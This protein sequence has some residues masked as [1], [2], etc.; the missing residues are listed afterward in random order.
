[1]GYIKM[2]KNNLKCCREA[3]GMSQAEVRRAIGGVKDDTYRGWESGERQITE[4][5]LKRIAKVLRCSIEDLTGESVTREE[6]EGVKA[7]IAR[8]EKK[9]E[10]HAAPRA[11]I[12]VDPVEVCERLGLVDSEGEPVVV[13]CFVRHAGGTGPDARMHT[14]AA[15][16]EQNGKMTVSVYTSDSQAIT[17]VDMRL[18][19]HVVTRK[20]TA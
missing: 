7:A 18:P 5:Y 13:G 12:Y 15:K 20:A 17:A 1:M 19:G 9:L 11:S 3:A 2:R 6:F 14:I 4:A 16:A 8:I 10:G